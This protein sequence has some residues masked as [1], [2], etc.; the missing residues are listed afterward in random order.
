ME[1]LS[2]S[3]QSLLEPR[4]KKLGLELS[5]YSFAN[6]YLFR[7]VH[8]FEVVQKQDVYVRGKTRDGLGYIMPTVAPE[9]YIWED[10]FSCLGENDVIFPIPQEWVSSFN[11]DQFEWSYSDIDTDYIYKATKMGHYP[12]RNLSS[13]RNL[14]KQFLEEYPNHRT[15]N[16]T[17]ENANDALQVLEEWHQTAQGDL[18]YS[19]YDACKEALQL[20][21]EVHLEGHLTYV[22]REPVGFL[23]GEALNDHTYCYQFAKGLKRYKGIYQYLY[24]ELALNI[25]QRY[26]WINLGQDIGSEGIR[27]SKRSYQPD[28]LVVKMRMRK[29]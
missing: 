14:L 2:L 6:L 24:E 8:A 10:L 16:L 4:F 29:K 19:D 12:G 11:S 18:K 23:I 15:V 22:D 5:E 7:E 17:K 25:E 26:E 3:H 9:A 1:P 27:H 20:L 13:R 28:R 21:A